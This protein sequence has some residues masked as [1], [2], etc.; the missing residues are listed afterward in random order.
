[1]NEA[2]HVKAAAALLAA[3]PACA[4][5]G[6]LASAIDAAHAIRTGQ[7]SSVEL[8]TR[9]LTRIGQYNPS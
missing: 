9:M 5:V 8:T 7:I 4:A 2:C 1:M 3:P 6:D